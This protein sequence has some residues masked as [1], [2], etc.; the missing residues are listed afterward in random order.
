MKRLVILLV[1]ILLFAGG[2]GAAWWFLLREAPADAAAAAKGAPA[3]SDPGGYIELAPMVLPIIRE[4]QVTL[5][6]T[7][8]LTVELVAPLSE[9]MQAKVQ[10]PLRD[11]IL[12][13][14]HAV[15]ALRYVQD[16][17]FEYPLVRSRL[18]RASERVLGAGAVKG[19]L[20]RNVTTRVPVGN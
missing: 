6:L 1:I 5:H 17:G 11:A 2:G 10:R 7:V 3:D 16:K 18:V 9:I 20:V 13:E 14:L 12:S 19:I 15:Y 4:G 8:A